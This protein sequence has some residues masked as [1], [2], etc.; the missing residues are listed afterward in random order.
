METLLLSRRIQRQ[1]FFLERSNTCLPLSSLPQYAIVRVEE[2]SALPCCSKLISPYCGTARDWQEIGTR[3]PVSQQSMPKERT[4]SYRRLWFVYCFNEPLLRNHSPTMTRPHH[5]ERKFLET[6][7]LR[8]QL[9]FFM[10]LAAGSPWRPAARA[11]GVCR[12]F[13]LISDALLARIPPSPLPP[14]SRL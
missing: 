14:S 8:P 2:I 9:P 5:K 10:L 11:S 6:L 4:P 7:P 12:G 3:L 13:V 1:C